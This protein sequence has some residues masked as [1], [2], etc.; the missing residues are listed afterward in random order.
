MRK[1]IPHGEDYCCLS[2]IFFALYLVGLVAMLCAITV[3]GRWETM[4]PIQITLPLV[5]VQAILVVSCCMAVPHLANAASRQVQ[6]EL[7]YNDLEGAQT[8]TPVV[9]TTI[10]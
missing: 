6:P 3:N 5:A 2:K 1:E 8:D 4:T 9:S 10:A 7:M